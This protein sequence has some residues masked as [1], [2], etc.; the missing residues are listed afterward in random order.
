L[1]D[2]AIT[3]P[4]AARQISFHQLLV[5]ARKTWLSDALSETLQR[6]DPAILKTELG[7]YVPSDVQQILAGAGIRDEYVFPV[8]SLLEAKPNLV[9]YYRL[10]LGIS[11]KTFYGTG[12]GM[13][14]FKSMETRG[15]LT[16]RQIPSLPAFCRAM[17]E[18]LADLVRQL[19]PAIS[20]RD[21]TELPL[22]SLGSQFQGANNNKIGRQATVDVFIAIAE[23]VEAYLQKR[24]EGRL[25]VK[26]A[27]G[28]TVVIGLA[29]DPDVRI[30]EEFGGAL[31]NKVAIEIKGGSDRSNAHNRAGEAEKS[32]QK[33]KMEGFRDYWTIIAKKGLDMRRLQSESPTTN[34]WFDVSQVLARQGED[35][36]EFCSRL[37]GEV[38]IPL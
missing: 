30:Q 32:H 34:S 35:W 28:R 6:V 7:Q 8:P 4:S 17:S 11:Q 21:V 24:D 23:I 16:P 3:P 27:S 37:A 29:T 5:A 22:L 1:N 12:S 25:L 9:G 2:P 19:S 18:G 36:E 20:Q 15:M 38:G 33:A 31:R 10:L 13:G 26:D 14:L